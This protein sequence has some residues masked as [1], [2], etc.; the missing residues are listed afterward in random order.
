MSDCLAALTVPEE[1][2]TEQRTCS[3][4]IHERLIVSHQS[5]SLLSECHFWFVYRRRSLS[6]F[7]L[8]AL[9][10]TTWLLHWHLEVMMTVSFATVSASSEI[11]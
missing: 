10:G 6:L 1:S 5:M 3:V 7:Q 2:L 11:S 9:A 4:R 8:C